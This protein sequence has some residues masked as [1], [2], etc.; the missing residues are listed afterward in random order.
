MLATEARWF[1]RGVKESIYIRVY[2]P[3]LN[4]DGGRYQLPPLW[5]STIK[6]H[7]KRRENGNPKGGGLSLFSIVQLS[8][9]LP[10]GQ[11]H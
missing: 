7:V 9:S 4:R 10:S 6:R 2:S 3:T 1:E 11:T 8:D 5:D